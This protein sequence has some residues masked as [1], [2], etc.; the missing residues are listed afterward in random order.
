M[1]K[2]HILHI[3]DDP[4]DAELI[5]LA[6]RA[7]VD[8]DIRVVGS[9]KECEQALEERSFDLVL[10][11]SHGYDFTASELLALVRAY[12]PGVPFIHVSGSFLDNDPEMLQARGATGCVLK[13]DPDAL[14][15]LV[16][17]V[18]RSLPG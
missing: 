18:A 3:E 16:Q 14:A 7:E 4:A 11:D 17:E 15:A 9:R 5:G 6:L 8:C 12:L 13:D 1:K 10:S 2:L